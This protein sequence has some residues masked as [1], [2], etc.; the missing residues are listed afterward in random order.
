MLF[1]LMFRTTFKGTFFFVLKPEKN[2]FLFYKDLCPCWPVP[3][4]LFFLSLGNMIHRRIGTGVVV[5]WLP[6]RGQS[7]LIEHSHMYIK[8][9]W[10]NHSIWQPSS[11]VRIAASKTG[12]IFQQSHFMVLVGL[13][14]LVSLCASVY[15]K[16]ARCLD[17]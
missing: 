17:K 13:V 10:D 8:Q 12:S 16:L 6:P 7:V 9:W 15:F 2:S 5:S 11:G 1:F 3:Y 4:L 14:S